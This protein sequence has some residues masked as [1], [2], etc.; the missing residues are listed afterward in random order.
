MGIYV[1]LALTIVDMVRAPLNSSV[2]IEGPRLVKLTSDDGNV[3]YLE[4]F[5]GYFQFFYR[6]K[7]FTKSMTPFSNRECGP[8]WFRKPYPNRSRQEQD[9]INVVQIFLLQSYPYL[10]EAYYFSG[11]FDGGPLPTKHVSLEKGKISDGEE[12]A[13]V[14]P[15][16]S[17]HVGAYAVE[18]TTVP[19]TITIDLG[20]ASTG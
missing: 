17:S 16:P 7:T 2:G 14:P 5:E 8:D 13:P 19:P 3:V 11:K 18:T 10:D 6:C 15:P 4:I 20:E 9:E 12:E 1:S